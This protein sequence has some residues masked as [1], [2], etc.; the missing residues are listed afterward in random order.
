MN[1]KDAQLQ[2]I[3]NVL[4]LL[5]VVLIAT[6]CGDCNR[7]IRDVPYRGDPLATDPYVEEDQIHIDEGACDSMGCDHFLY[8]MAWFHNPTDTQYKADILCEFWTDSDYFVG[9]SL[10]EGVTI[11][12]SRS[13]EL[14]FREQFTTPDLTMFRLECELQ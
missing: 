10:R 9:D 6:G 5:V 12:A 1:Q 11:D 14:E 3:L 7:E 13:K 8:G 4:A 2:R